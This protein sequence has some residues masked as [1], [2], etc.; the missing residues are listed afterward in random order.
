M[1]MY[2]FAL[3]HIW[4]CLQRPEAMDDSPGTGVTE[5][6]WVLGKEL[7][8]TGRAVSPLNLRVISSAPVIQCW[9]Q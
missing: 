8:S 1:Q 2:V 9:R 7:G 5:L 4:R 3:A 6:M